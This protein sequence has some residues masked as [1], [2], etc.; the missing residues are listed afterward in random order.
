MSAAAWARWGVQAG[1]VPASTGCGGG[2]GHHSPEPH[3]LH[4][5]EGAQTSVPS[6]QWA[7]LGRG[8]GGVGP[9]NTSRA[10]SGVGRTPHDPVPYLL[11]ADCGSPPAGRSAGLV[12]WLGAL[13]LQSW[14]QSCTTVVMMTAAGCKGCNVLQPWG[15]W[16]SRCPRFQTVGNGR[17]ST[18]RCCWERRACSIHSP[19]LQCQSLYR[20]T[21]SVRTGYRASCPTDPASPVAWW[22]QSGPAEADR[23]CPCLTEMTLQQVPMTDTDPGHPLVQS[24][25]GP[26]CRSRYPGTTQPTCKHNFTCL[27][28]SSRKQCKHTN[29]LQIE[30]SLTHYSLHWN[31]WAPV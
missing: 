4:H 9:C 13:E 29:S 15:S 27:K 14:V 17:W 16:S 22:M 25:A 3:L 8:S 28:I 7:G 2:G 20:C 11:S 12:A 23:S 31:Y 30:L 5:P 24:A 1:E 10:G 26:Q 21:H 19:H 6:V 18:A